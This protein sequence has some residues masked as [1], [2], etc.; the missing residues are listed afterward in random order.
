MIVRRGPGI[1]LSL[2]LSAAAFALA[3]SAMADDVGTAKDVDPCTI[4]ATVKLRAITRDDG[5]IEVTGIVWSND[6]NIWDWKFKHNGELSFD[7]SVIAEG[8]GAKSFKIERTMLPSSPD[9]ITF[10]A[11]NRANNQVCR[12]EINYTP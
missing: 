3:P 7:G 12:A 6:D 10:R 11:E 5:R 4:A 1:V 9:T 8:D 2:A